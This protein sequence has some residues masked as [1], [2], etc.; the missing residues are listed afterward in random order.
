VDFKNTI[1]IMT[2]NIGSQ[3]ILGYQGAFDGAGYEH[4]KDAVLDEMRQHFRPE[5]LNR[6][7][8]VIVFHALDEDHLKK[9]V[10][11]QL[12]RVR[13]RLADRHITL[14]LTDAAKTHLVRVGYDPAYGARPLKRAIQR[15]VENPLARQILEGKVKDGQTVVGDYAVSKGMMVFTAK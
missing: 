6:V 1:V 3:R 2:S 9:I 5:F 12:G 8:E 7:D 4:M 13:S 11:I 10:T 14:D 15:E